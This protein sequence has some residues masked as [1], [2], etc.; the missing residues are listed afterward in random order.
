MCGE[1]V[2]RGIIPSTGGIWGPPGGKSDFGD[3]ERWIAEY[4]L[5]D[6]KI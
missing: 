3:P 1:N 5:R 4:I 6:V 2:G